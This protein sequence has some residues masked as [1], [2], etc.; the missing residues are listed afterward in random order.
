MPYPEISGFA[1]GNA[2]AR[3]DARVRTDTRFFACENC[4][5]PRAQRVDARDAHEISC[6]SRFV[7]DGSVEEL[8][9]LSRARRT[10]SH[11]PA[12]GARTEAIPMLSF[13]GHL[14]FDPLYWGP[15][16]RGG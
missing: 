3:V 14:H 1:R 11:A 5:M 9:R 6:A 8:Q 2:K 10:E 13:R 16:A 12:K 7:E 15:L 4:A